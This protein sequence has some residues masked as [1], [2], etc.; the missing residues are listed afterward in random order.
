LKERFAGRLL[1]EAMV[2]QKSLVSARDLVAPL[3]AAGTVEEVAVGEALVTEG[4][5]D[6]DVF[7]ILAGKFEIQLKGNRNKGFR[8]EGDLV[9]DF[10]ASRPTISR[11]ASLIATE[12]NAVLK[13]SLDDLRRI[14]DDNAGFWKAM[15]EQSVTRLVE[16][17]ASFKACNDAPRIL[18]FSSSEAREAMGEVVIQMATQ[19]I[20]VETWDNI[21]SIS[22]YPVPDLL[23][24]LDR[25]DFAIAIAS[26]DDVVISRKRSK[27]APRDN[28][29]FE[30]GLAIGRLGLERSFL[31]CE[32]GRSM[33]LPS[34]LFGLNY[35]PYKGGSLLQSQIQAACEKI[36][37]RVRK[38]GVLMR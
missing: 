34:D 24:A 4:A 30:F 2:K 14:T 28:V 29:T 18:I 1:E 26:A 7:F 35:V 15:N 19:E 3:I 9:G 32:S 8:G 38:D 27:T 37:R 13:V 20:I 5:E 33:K 25:S 16:R 22:Q 23:K 10:V 21:F 31:L 11:S 6:T 12:P 17:N 36:A